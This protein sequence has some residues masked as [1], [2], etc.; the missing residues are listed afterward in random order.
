M[1]SHTP[2]HVKVRSGSGKQASSEQSGAVRCLVLRSLYLAGIPCRAAAAGRRR[3]TAIGPTRN[4]L[5]LDRTPPTQQQRATPPSR[6][7][8]PGLA[9]ERQLLW[10]AG[11][12]PTHIEPGRRHTGACGHQPL[13]T[14]GRPDSGGP[15]G[16]QQQPL[17]TDPRAS[18]RRCTSTLPAMSRLAAPQFFHT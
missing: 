15:A 18:R 2:T 6:R 14:A 16:G 13:A 7:A 8:R 11:R 4:D 5:H 10:P 17:P 3:L 12:A 1:I 9:G